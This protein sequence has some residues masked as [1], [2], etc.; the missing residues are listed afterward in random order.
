[1]II[2]ERR[3]NELFDSLPVIVDDNAKE[4]KPTFNFGTHE[5]LLRFLDHKK[6][7]NV[8]F[9]PII[10]LETPFTLAGVEHRKTFDLKLVLAQLSNYELSNKQRLEITFEKTL[11]PLY[12]NVLKALKE[13]GFTRIINSEN[14][15]VTNHYN[16]SVVEKGKDKQFASDVWD[17]IK[18]ECELQ[19]DVTK[20]KIIN[21]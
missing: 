17:A 10:W 2:V 15:K 21:Y 1:M 8:S 7:Q 11:E 3:L 12:R 9:Y 14:N 13:G 16:Y 5:D 19:I 4:F 18:F 6:K 20:Q